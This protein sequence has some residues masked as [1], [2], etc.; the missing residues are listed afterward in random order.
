MSPIFVLLIFG[1]AIAGA[2]FAHFAAKERREAFARLARQLGLRFSPEKDYG[3]ADQLAFLDR[4][5]RGSNRYAYN[6]MAGEYQ[7]QRVRVFD[8]HYKTGSGKNTK[9]HYFSFF[10]LELN[11]Y[12][13]ELIIAP[14]G[15]MSKVAQAFGYDDIDFE[16]HEFS[17]QFCV[18]SADKKFAYDFCH[19]K[20]MEYLLANR[21]LS[22]EI[23]GSVMAIAFS[24][25]LEPDQIP[26]NL[27]RLI[28]L[29]S[30]MPEYLFTN[31]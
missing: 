13:P 6:I 9:H 20:M 12:F 21:D 3:L 27:Q 28:T 31:R 15:F 25:C 23:E 30:L 8:Y 11:G 17:R 4:L 26:G 10:V 5:D 1:I 19:G 18:R 22:V 24:H 14:E 7:G 2:V 16:S 29:R